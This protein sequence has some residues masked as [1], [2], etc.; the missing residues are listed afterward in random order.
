VPGISLGTT[1]PTATFRKLE[2]LVAE[3]K[4]SSHVMLRASMSPHEIYILN[5]SLA[6]AENNRAASPNS[7]PNGSA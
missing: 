6:N 3:H 2:T 7:E 5:R 4:L 1:N